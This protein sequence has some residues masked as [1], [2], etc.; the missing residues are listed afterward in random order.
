[1]N[2]TVLAI[3]KLPVSYAQR[4]REMECVAMEREQDLNAVMV[5]RRRVVI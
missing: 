5:K 1:M 2:T 4:P 3:V